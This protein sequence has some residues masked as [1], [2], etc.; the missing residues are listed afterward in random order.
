M[1][2]LEKIYSILGFV[3]AA[4]KFKYIFFNIS[5][6]FSLNSL[7]YVF[8]FGHIQHLAREAPFR[9]VKRKV[10]GVGIFFAGFFWP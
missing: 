7:S 9:N 2:S 1:A 3:L 6:T 8:S 4:D 10:W 5:V